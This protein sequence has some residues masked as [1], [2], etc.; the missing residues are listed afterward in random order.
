MTGITRVGKETMFSDL[1]HLNV[2]SMTSDEYATCFGFTEA[3]VEDALKEYGL[4]GKK[5]VVKKWY[6]GFIIGNHR[7]IYNPW[8]IIGFLSKKK[9]ANY[10]VNTSRNALA[11]SLVRR[12][13]R[14]LKEQFEQ[15]LKGENIECILD[16]YIVFPRLEESNDAIF[17]LLFSSGFLR[18][19]TSETETDE[20]ETR[21]KY[22][23]KLTNREVLSMFEYLIGD[24]F[25]SGNADYNDFLKALLQADTEAMNEYMNR[26]SLKMFSSFDTGNKASEYAEP[27]RFYHGF[28]LGLMVELKDNYIITSNKE[29]G[30]GRY[31]VVLEP[32]DKS[33]KAFILEFK[34][35]K[36]KKEKDLEA[37]VAEALRQIE[38]K[39]YAKDLIERGISPDNIYSFGFA[40]QG[41][42]VLIG[43]SNK[44]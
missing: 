38:E 5:E 2:A 12:G 14:K 27:E 9:I 8:S 34:V 3:E 16:E 21:K 18:V 26:I 7:D 25:G 31:D 4:N 22:S 17:S 11:G 39:Q 20:E 10:W 40:F 41:K 33:G 24:W 36:P 28:V 37:T 43:E 1:N 42:E 32:R 23:L 44:V 29:S 19:A 15:L 30:F 35:H 13:D 6:N